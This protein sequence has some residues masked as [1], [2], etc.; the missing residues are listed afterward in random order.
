MSPKFL[1]TS[2][3]LSDRKIRGHCVFSRNTSISIQLMN[4][5]KLNAPE[6]T[7]KRKRELRL[8]H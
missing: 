4:M 1:R 3:T 5:Q 8:K 7:L 2:F 6:L